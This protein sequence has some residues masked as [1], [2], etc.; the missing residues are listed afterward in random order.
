MGIPNGCKH[1]AGQSAGNEEGRMQNEERSSQHNWL[2]NVKY[3][4]LNF[5]VQKECDR[6]WA[7]WIVQREKRIYGSSLFYCSGKKD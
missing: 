6:E 4:D 7:G 2:A 1:R 3:C 5:C